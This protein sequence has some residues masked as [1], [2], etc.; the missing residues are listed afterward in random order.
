MKVVDEIKRGAGTVGRAAMQAIH[1]GPPDFDS[2]ELAFLKRFDAV[3]MT[4]LERRYALLNAVRYVVR[5][6]I[7]GALVECGVWRGGSMM[8]VAQTL[9]HLGA[10]DRHLHL[11]D[12]FEGMSKPGAEDVDFLG[13]SAADRMD[14][15][16]KRSGHAMWA[17]ASLA[18]V[19]ANMRQTGYPESQV[20][21]R[22]GKVEDTVPGQA[23]DQIAVLRLDTDW[24]ESTRHELVHLY[25]RVARGGVIII[26][27]YGYWKGA[28][29]A[30][31]EF[32][33]SIPDAI[34]LNRIDD[35]GRIAIKP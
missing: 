34:L 5:H 12:T 18:D 3:T 9:R 33:A 17:I 7:P 14:K 21:F 10:T 2:A 19:Q 32:L 28:R 20:H 26:D 31:D 25:P 16:A 11:F 8:L 22:V 6:R 15:T 29:K 23:P 35:T 24:Y 30:V 4:S 13:R 27:D 1:G